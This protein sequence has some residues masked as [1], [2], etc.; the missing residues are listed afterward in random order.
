MRIRVFSWLLLMSLFQILYLVRISGQCLND[1]R[2]LLVQFKKGLDFDSLSSNKLV[3]WDPNIDCCNW[4]GVVCDKESGNIISLSLENEFISDGLE[5]S[6]ALFNLQFLEKLNL[7]FNTFN[8]VQIPKGLRNLTNLVYLNL[9][10]AGFGGQVPFEL[11]TMRKLVALDLSAS[12]PGTFPLKLENPNLKILVQNLTELRELYLDGVDIS[13]QRYD[14]SQ[15]LSSLPNL[16]NLSMKNCNLSGPLDYSLSQLPSL[17]V[18]RLDMNNLSTEV[19]EFFAQFQYLTI[20]SLSS[21]SLKGRFPEVIFQAH[22]LQILDLSDNALLNG[23]ISRFPQN[24]AFRT[25]VLSHTNFSG[26]LPDSISNLRMLSKIDL[27][28]CNFTGLIPSS[29]ANLT[30][31]VYLDFSSN[32]F[33]GSIPLFHMSKKLTYID[34]SRNSLT[35]S[36][37]SMPFEGLSDLVYIDLGSNLLSGSIPRSLFSLPSLQRLQLSNNNF[38]G[39][40]D[41]FSTVNSSNLDT[42]DLRSNQLKGLI[43]ESFFKLE[44]LKVLLL[45]SNSFNGTVKLEKIQSLRNLSSL[46]LGDNFLSVDV[47]S[48]SQS[49]QL[50][51]LNLASCDLSDF[52]DLRNQPKLTYLD[53]SNNRISGEIPSWVW[54][55]GNGALAHLNLSQNLLVNFQK[56]F[57]M[58]TYLSVLDLHSNGIQGEFPMPPESA[59][60]VDYSN[61]SFQQAIPVKIGQFTSFAVFFSLANNG[62]SGTI[63]ESLCN[64][65]YLQ[66][67]DLSGNNLSGSIPTCLMVKAENFGVLNIGRNNISGFIPDTFP[68]NCNLKT[69]DL[70]EN[71]LEGKIPISLAKCRSLEVVNIGNNQIED[72]FPCM[73]KNSS[74]LRVL[75]LRNNRFHGE[76]RCPNVDEGWPNLQIIDIASNNFTGELYPKCISS[77]KGM[78]LDNDAQLGR[79]HLRFDFLYLNKFYY[80]DTVTV[81][82]KGLEME[83]VKILTVFTSIDF[84]CNDFHGQIP[85]RVGDLKSLYVLN[86]SHNS[87][88]GPIPKFIGNLSQLGSLDLSANHL[89]GKIPEELKSLNFLSVLNLSYN[90]LSGMIPTSSQLQ[91]F[92]PASYLG[93]LGLCGF[94]LNKSC[95]PSETNSSHIL[96]QNEFS[97][98]FIFI[99]LGYGFGAALVIAPLALCKRWREKCNDQVDQLLKLIY[100]GYGFSYMR[101]GGKI[102]AVENIEDEITD[103]DDDD[104]DDDEDEVEDELSDGRYCVFCTKLDIEMKKAMHD[105]KCTCYYTPPSVFST[106]T[107]TSSSSSLLVVYH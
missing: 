64:S 85:D 73:L 8:R 103:D 67:L 24:G 79:D 13:A 53:L 34:L 82:F 40:V 80:Q 38:S 32:S 106:P 81:T 52:P 86:L 94:P 69:L 30:E 88:A 77:W 61:N 87:L 91:T 63:P 90:K 50:T 39:R 43:P 56:P 9:S 3:N 68:V 15:A 102:E 74:S 28:S 54:G 44:R 104:D 2:D 5:N 16:R 29:M 89:S 42:L 62:I 58:S 55:I 14:W 20:L 60:Y 23:T 7:A 107:S 71:H 33:N 93:N 96:K 100:P 76:I 98:Q 27:S 45:S 25:I 101:Y 31:L 92:S 22:A 47:S 95:T 46:E 41:E 26:S 12:F 18:L 65:S 78:A 66:V 75:V 6:T 35:G 57:N 70:S 21:C 51:R 84:S 72:K 17:S 4:D 37:S 97:W 59:I 36:L 1:Q 105:P 48:L 11:S 49:P 10:N 19:P 99:G 83:L